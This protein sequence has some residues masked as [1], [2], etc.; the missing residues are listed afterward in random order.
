MTLHKVGSET[1]WTYG[2]VFGTCVDI[3]DSRSGAL[4]VCSDRANLYVRPGDSGS[5]VFIV[6]N[7]VGVTFVGV[8]WGG[9]GVQGAMSNLT[10][11]RQDLGSIRTF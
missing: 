9:D 4:I 5:P 3:R 7:S 2:D 1:G 8:V 10:Q 6:N 11:I